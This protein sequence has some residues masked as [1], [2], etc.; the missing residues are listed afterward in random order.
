MRAAGRTIGNDAV[1]TRSG[2]R[3]FKWRIVEP[4]NAG[5][6]VLRLVDNRLDVYDE[7]VT[8]KNPVRLMPHPIE[9]AL[10]LGHRVPLKF[11]RS[12]SPTAKE[13]MAIAENS[14]VVAD[15]MAA[16]SGTPYVIDSSKS[17]VRLKLLYSI[18]PDRV[19]VVELVRDGRAV[20]A[21]AMRRS[22]ISAT[23][24]ARIWKRDNQNL[25]VMLRTVPA[26]LRIR[27]KYEDVCENPQR[28]LQRVCAFLGLQFEPSMTVLWQRPVHNIPG[29]PMLF[30]RTRRTISRDDRWQRDLSPDDLRVFNQVAGRLN[31]RFG[32]R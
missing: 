1:L 20:T 7:T 19:R 12:L 17:P 2:V 21:S 32:Y 24:A 8:W 26:P 15:A 18:R 13:Y 22:R 29:N 30:N 25:A 9:V 11:V 14:W 31:T 16:V 27:V 3:D 23:R 10:A 4:G 28:E 6:H 5:R